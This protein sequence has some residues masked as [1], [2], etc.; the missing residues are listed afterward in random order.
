[1]SK[2]YVKISIKDLKAPIGC[3]GELYKK[4]GI[5]DIFYSRAEELKIGHKNYVL[6]QH[7]LCN[8]RTFNKLIAL[9]RESWIWYGIDRYTGKL[10]KRSTETRHKNPT[11]LTRSDESALGMDALAWS[12]STVLGDE[13]PDDEIWLD[14]DLKPIHPAE[15]E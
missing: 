3:W 7:I 15:G 12:P 1:M 14:L 2:N 4:L 13:V 9:I 5:I 10:K 11:K 6:P 8:D